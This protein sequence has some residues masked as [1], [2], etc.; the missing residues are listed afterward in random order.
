M[1]PLERAQQAVTKAQ[2]DYLQDV[3]K[4]GPRSAAAI[5]SSYAFRDAQDA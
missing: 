2:N 5:A 1:T 3:D 4:Y